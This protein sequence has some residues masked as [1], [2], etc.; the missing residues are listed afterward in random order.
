MDPTIRR[1]FFLLV[2]PVVDHV[3]DVVYRDIDELL[4]RV[5][6]YYHV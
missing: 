6:S 5:P 1:W 4:W 3:P 2:H